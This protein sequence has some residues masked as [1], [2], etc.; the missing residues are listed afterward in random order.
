MLTGGLTR[1]TAHSINGGGK[2]QNYELRYAYEQQFALNQW[3]HDYFLF[4]V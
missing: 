1:F 3:P 4:G 2:Q